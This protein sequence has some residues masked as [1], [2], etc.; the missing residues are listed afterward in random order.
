MCSQRPFNCEFRVSMRTDPYIF[1]YTGDATA[2]PLPS[3]GKNPNMRVSAQSAHKLKLEGAWTSPV[4]S[5]PSEI[6]CG[7][8]MTNNL[9][10]YFQEPLYTC[11]K[12]LE[13]DESCLR[14]L[15][16]C[17]ILIGYQLHLTRL[18]ALFLKGRVRPGGCVPDL[19]ETHN[20]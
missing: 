9:F 7:F 12:S 14:Y 8:S 3:K 16:L 2:H 11:Q 1:A 4:S 13:I 19:Q 5:I 6:F 15:E 20:R 10:L 17:L 18:H